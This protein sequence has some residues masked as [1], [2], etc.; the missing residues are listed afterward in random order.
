LFDLDAHKLAI[1]FTSYA[2]L[3]LSLS[4]HE[5]AHAWMALRM[6]DDTAARLGRITLNPLAHM[7]PIGTVLMPLLQL[8]GSGLPFLAW[9]KPTP[10]QPQ[11]F[12]KLAKGQILVAAAGPVSNFGL[13]ILFTTALLL[14]KPLG[15]T[16]DAQSPVFVFLFIGVSLNVV[17]GVFNLVPIP[18]L[19]GSKVASWLLPRE[20]GSSY[21]RVMEPYGYFILMALLLTGVLWWVVGPI[22]DFI[23]RQLLSLVL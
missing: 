14:T 9:A 21:D 18:P 4:V 15:V 10:V 17:L 13:A 20:I 8:F 5:S 6:G 11:N 22:V 2:V 1:G 3:L 16:P 23:Q 7:D 12:R 19:D